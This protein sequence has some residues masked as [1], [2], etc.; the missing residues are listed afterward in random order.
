MVSISLVFVLV[1]MS[2][3]CVISAES[4]EKLKEVVKTLS[5]IHHFG[6]I[7]VFICEE[8]W[9]DFDDLFQLLSSDKKYPVKPKLLI[10]RNFSRSIKMEKVISGSLFSLVLADNHKSYILELASNILRGMR[11]DPVIF[12]FRRKPLDLKEMLNTFCMWTYKTQFINS[13]VMFEDSVEKYG[14]ELFPSPQMIN[15]TL[16]PVASLLSNSVRNGALDFRGK[17]FRFP[18]ADDKP[19]AFSAPFIGMENRTKGYGV[20]YQVFKNF[21]KHNNGKIDPYPLYGPDEEYKSM[22]EVLKMVEDKTIISSPSCFSEID[23]EKFSSSYPLKTVDW[24]FMVPVVGKIPSFEYISIPFQLETK[25]TLAVAIILSGVVFWLLGELENFSLGLL[26][27]VCG[28]LALGFCTNLDRFHVLSSRCFQIFIRVA[29]FIFS[30]FYNSL[31]SSFLATTLYGKQ[32]ETLLELDQSGLQVMIRYNDSMS[33][34]KFGIPSFFNKH[35]LIKRRN[36]VSDHRD[37]LDASFAYMVSSDRWLFIKGQQSKM[38]LNRLR[39]SNVCYAQFFLSFLLWYD[40][41]FTE[42]LNHFIIKSLSSGLVNFWTN[43]AYR[44]YEKYIKKNVSFIE[45]DATPMDLVLATPMDLTYFTYAW[46]C[47]IVGSLASFGIFIM[48]GVYFYN[49]DLL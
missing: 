23:P 45:S 37:N 20:C 34:Q 1:M 32:I 36:I 11:Q 7:T 29:G 47:L 2:N 5:N 43:K 46:W 6:T 14:C 30:I 31:L 15:Q 39:Y 25:L 33:L 9:L 17:T 12:F 38:R 40:N 44:D 28:F 49:K 18:I 48:E 16:L 13:M 4:Y 8:L 24:C 19:R 42:P 26:N 41:M 22:N 21:I 27:G 10:T 3:I 35:F